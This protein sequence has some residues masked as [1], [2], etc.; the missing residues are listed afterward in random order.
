MHYKKGIN[1]SVADCMSR[2]ATGNGATGEVEEEIPCFA[3]ED[4]GVEF[5]EEEVYEVDWIELE[6][7]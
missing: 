3:T 5:K 7:E 1:K 2:R 6:D 4:R